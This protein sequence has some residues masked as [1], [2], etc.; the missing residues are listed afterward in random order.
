[1]PTYVYRVRATWAGILCETGAYLS[2][3]QDEVY[4]STDIM[5]Q[6]ANKWATLAADLLSDQLLLT[7][8]YF[9]RLESGYPGVTFIPEDWPVVGTGGTTNPMNI[10]DCVN[11]R[12]TSLTAGL[13]HSNMLQLPGLTEE[14]CSAGN[15]LA[16]PLAAY[17]SWAEDL[18]TSSYVQ[19]PAVYSHVMWSPTAL[20]E[21]PISTVAVR[22]KV[23]KRSSRES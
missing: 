14:Q 20:V 1:M 5:Q 11:V 12:L 2:G 16:T 8:L 17:F 7:S 19:A 15:I 22:Q 21:K 4:P 6:I 3:N 23:G 13:P 9:R 10:R 18:L